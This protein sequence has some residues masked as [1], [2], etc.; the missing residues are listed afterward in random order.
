MLVIFILIG[1]LN[2]VEKTCRK[3]HVYF[4]TIIPVFIGQGN[5]MSVQFLHMSLNPAF[6]TA[7]KKVGFIHA[8][9]RFALILHFEDS[10]L[11][12]FKGSC[13]NIAQFSA[14]F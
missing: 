4:L 6:K 13:L 3:V 11:S 5:R 9:L 10:A 2:K 14:P 1:N 12:I 8:R 7:S